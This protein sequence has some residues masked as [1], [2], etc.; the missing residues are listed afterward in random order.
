MSD[1]KSTAES[2]LQDSRDLFA[3]AER[4]REELRS[5]PDGDPSRTRLEEMIRELL[6][7]SRQIAKTATKVVKS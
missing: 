4:Y 2:L 7:K 1:R 5:L 3:R 6:Q